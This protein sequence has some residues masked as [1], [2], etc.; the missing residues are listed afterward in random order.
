MKKPRLTVAIREK[1]DGLGCGTE[2]MDELSLL[3]V[4][5]PPDSLIAEALAF[6]DK[7]AERLNI[8]IEESAVRYQSR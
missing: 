3:A 7:E 1:L 6:L 8:G 5:L 4:T 2:L